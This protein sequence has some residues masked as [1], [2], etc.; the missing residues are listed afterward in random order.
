MNRQK[1]NNS[2]QISVV[3]FERQPI[4]RYGLSF[5]FNQSKNYNLITTIHHSNELLKILK[6]HQPDVLLMEFNQ[7]GID[8]PRLLRQI[9]TTHQNTR[10]LIYS[11]FKYP[12][13]IKETFNAGAHGYLHKDA[14]DEKV[15]NAINSIAKGKS[16]MDDTIKL[17]SNE[18]IDLEMFDSAKK[19]G[20][21]LNQYKL[22]DRECD[23]LILLSRGLSSEKTATQLNI[24]KHTV[25]TH[26]KNMFKKLNVKNLTELVRFAVENGF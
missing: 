23:V 6:L 18:L 24:S 16:Y 26:K 7:I 8:I 17:T 14:L 12:K 22:S 21:Y 1:N 20:I 15:L 19:A 10:I 2:T 5:I 13:L 3:L 9:S 25:E 4:I 11:T